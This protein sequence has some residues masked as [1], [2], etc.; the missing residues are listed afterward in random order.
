MG[1]DA[2]KAAVHVWYDTT[3]YRW[4]DWCIHHSCSDSSSS[5]GRTLFCRSYGC[6]VSIA[7]C[8]EQCRHREGY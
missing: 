3:Y 4:V 1:G 6:R 8:T 7:F 5:R 2:I